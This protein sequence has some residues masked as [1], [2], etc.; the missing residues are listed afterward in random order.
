[1]EFGDFDP[2]GEMMARRQYEALD[3]GTPWQLLAGRARRRMTH[4]AK[5]W[6]NS[7]AIQQM[8]IDQLSQRDPDE[9][10]AGWLATISQLAGR[11]T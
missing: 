10:I 9:E 6:L 11:Y 8:T 1:M 5:R 2:V 4:R 3:T 7:Q